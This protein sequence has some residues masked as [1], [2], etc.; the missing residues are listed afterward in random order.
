MKIVGQLRAILGLDKT[1]FDRGLTQAEQRTNRFSAGIKR[2]GI[3][4]AAAFSVTAIFGFLKSVL[5]GYDVQAKAEQ[6]L[7]IALKGREDVQRRLIRQA[8]SL[9]RT[10]LF[11]DE[12]TI[13]AASR[14]AMILGVNET[15]IRRLLPLVQDLATAKFEGNLVTAA[16][17][18]AK[19]VGSSTNAL[20]RYAIEIEGTVG[21][22]A[23]LESAIEQLNKQV[24]GQAEAA[25]R[26]G[27]GAFTQL[28]NI[29]GDL[30]ESL[31]AKM[32]EKSWVQ[33]LFD[34]GR[35]FVEIYQQPE[36]GFLKGI[37]QAWTKPNETIAAIREQ[38]KAEEEVIEETKIYERTIA[39]L[40]DEIKGYQED[41]E[42]TTVSDQAHR[43]EL[44]KKIADLE[45]L[46]KKYT[47]LEQVMKRAEPITKIG[48]GIQPGIGVPALPGIQPYSGTLPL[49]DEERIQ[50]L[51]EAL[52]EQQ[53]AVNILSSAF[54]ALF[55]STEDGFKA[56]IDSIIMSLKRLI[57][58][59]MGKVIILTILNAL[60][61][62][63]LKFGQIISTAAGLGAAKGASGGM[64][65]P[66]Y[67]NDTFPLL[68]SSGETLLTEQQSRN[69][70]RT[71]EVYVRGDI[72]GRGIALSGRRSE[73]DN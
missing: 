32:M 45:E 8:Q 70:N 72:L 34:W 69:F 40:R 2:L 41:I 46:I 16:E 3:T 22:A 61:G 47:T 63:G 38:Q 15:A 48:G 60:T 26:V 44:L 4:M 33:D 67:P 19:S 51:T 12:E 35:M 24:G 11:G 5:Q 14:L 29:I 18:V 23:R 21:S 17:L 36:T 42:S 58:E 13:E 62:G 39:D 10:T 50:S 55:S 7:F 68:A 66:G 9:Q 52:Y 27:I 30:K 53:T 1:K 71:I 43:N 56:M 65:P 54:D 37:W 25:A 64:V 31:G 20:S 57:A 49:T 6:K 59:L 73:P 28:K